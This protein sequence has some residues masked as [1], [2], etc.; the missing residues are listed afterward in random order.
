MKLRNAYEI[1]ELKTKPSAREIWSA[2]PFVFRFVYAAD[3]RSFFWR[4][5][6][7]LLEAPIGFFAILSVKRLSETLL[8]LDLSGCILWASIGVG[9]VIVQSWISIFRNRSDDYLR[10]AV[11]Y[12]LDRRSM[13]HIVSLP[14]GIIDQP[15]FRRLAE[16]YTRK[17]WVMLSIL[18]YAMNGL[19]QLSG[20]IGLSSVLFFVP[21]QVSLVV[22]I[23]CIARIF[24]ASKEAAWSWSI[25]DDELRE[26]RRAVYYQRSLTTPRDALHI[27]SLDL[28]T[29]FLSLWRGLAEKL[30]RRSRK[31]A[32]TQAKAFFISDSLEAV[33]MG[34]GLF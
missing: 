15:S 18:Q 7:S 16:A 31:M 21:W 19:R 12:A 10:F 1:P 8:V 17:S 24:L 29:S 14:F 9:V 25:F 27:L 11:D 20:L 6:L 5:F 22:F 28:H 32:N 23:A 34:L 30:L 13:E 26:G 4:I 33:G 3:K 2:V